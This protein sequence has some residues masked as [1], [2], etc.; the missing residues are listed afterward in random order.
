MKRQN[1][2]QKAL[3]RIETEGRKH[4]LCIYSA[5]AMALWQYWGKKKEAINRLFDLSHDVWKECAKDHDHSM[6][7]M[8]E[9]ET[10]IEIQNGDGKSWRDLLY[11]NASLDT[12]IMTPAKMLWMRQQQVKWVAPQI[13]ACLLIAMH[14]KHGF[15]YDRC[16]RLYQQVHEI[17]DDYGS[18]VEKI[19]KACLEE[20]GVNITDI[21]DG[22]Q[23]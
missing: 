21:L 22:E 16:Q 19:R 9:E 3:R 6:I 7:Q 18:D 10:S 12:G 17:I 4:C 23:E 8:C 20:T 5:T 15:G 2:L 11:L 13:M 14:R 1:P